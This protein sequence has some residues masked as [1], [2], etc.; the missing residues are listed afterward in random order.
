MLYRKRWAPG[1]ALCAALA[2]AGADARAEGG[3]GGA[4]A[5]TEHAR[6]KDEGARGE[7]KVAGRAL[8][9]PVDGLRWGMTRKQLEE[10]VDR[11]I[12]AD[13]VEARKQAR[14]TPAQRDLEAQV[15]AQKAA[16]RRSYVELSEG[17][18]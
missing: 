2:A 14:S 17:P 7:G 3:R 15:V 11:R 6:A 5:K 18:D 4:K 9:L 10:C 1:L 13:S 8:A 12:E 16:F